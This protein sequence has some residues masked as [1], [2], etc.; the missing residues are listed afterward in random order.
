MVYRYGVSNDAADG[1][2]TRSPVDDIRRDASA[3]GL[4]DHA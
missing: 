4:A 1:T 2:I 3:T